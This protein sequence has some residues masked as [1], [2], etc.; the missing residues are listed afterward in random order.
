MRGLGPDPTGFGSGSESDP[1]E[2]SHSQEKF[3]SNRIVTKQNSEFYRL[4]ILNKILLSEQNSVSIVLQFCCSIYIRNKILLFEQN[5]ELCLVRI[6]QPLISLDLNSISKIFQTGDATRTRPIQN[7]HTQTQTRA[8]L[9]LSQFRVG[10]D[11]LCWGGVTQSIFLND[12]LQQRNE[13]LNKQ[14]LLPVRN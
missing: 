3:S 6:L 12:S 10:P 9:D 5:S 14:F 8:R 4:H 13:K 11:G 2:S 7:F 1:K